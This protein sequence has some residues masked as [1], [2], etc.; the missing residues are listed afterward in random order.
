MAR[1]YANW[2][3]IEAQPWVDGWV[4]RVTANLAID[5]ARRRP[6]ALEPPPPVQSEDAIATRLAMVAA[7]GHLPRRQ[8]EAISLY[9]LAGM[10]EADVANVLGISSGTLKSHLHRGL[11]ALRARLGEGLE[12]VRLAVE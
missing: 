1:A 8:R 11:V 5:V 4:L 2:E 6:V 3:R 12:E 10:S 7:L 9:Y